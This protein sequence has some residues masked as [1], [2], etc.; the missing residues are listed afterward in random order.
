MPK[1]MNAAP[2][3]TP[4]SKGLEPVNALCKKLPGGNT[5]PATRTR[6][7]LY[8]VDGIRLPAIRIG[9]KWF[10]TPEAIDWFFEERTRKLLASADDSQGDVPSQSDRSAVGL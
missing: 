7:I 8:G 4:R 6:W 9:R 3:V 10:S 5:T 2:A 1:L